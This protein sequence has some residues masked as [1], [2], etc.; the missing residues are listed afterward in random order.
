M[1]RYVMLS[2][3]LLVLIVTLI[4]G[5]RSEPVPQA[6]DHQDWLH[7]AAAFAALTCTARLAFAR[8]HLCWIVLYCL[9][10]SLG[11]ELAQGLLP[12]RTASFDD[13][14]ANVAGV[15]LGIV[16]ATLFRRLQRVIP[17]QALRDL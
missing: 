6:F 14:L 2:C 13:M 3:F 16:A 4:A 17:V 5:L 7:H 8:C 12:R 15:C 9:L 10:L 11:I 1:I